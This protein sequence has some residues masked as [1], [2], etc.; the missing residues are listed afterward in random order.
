MQ[1]AQLLNIALLLPAICLFGVAA[2]VDVRARRIPNGLVFAVML[3]AVLRMILRFDVSVA[4]HDIKLAGLLVI[5]LLVLWLLRWLGGGDVKLMFA[6]AL[7]V[8]AQGLFLFVL[9]TALLGGLI[10][11]V[12]V[13]DMWCE[14]QYGWSAGIA[15]PRANMA[16]RHPGANLPRKAAVPYGLAISLGCLG[17]LFSTVMTR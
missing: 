3:L 6:G 14:R 12:A 10:G 7:L 8:G 16:F 11:L 5:G 13:I 9:S 4:L 2:L 1:N 15:F 17:T